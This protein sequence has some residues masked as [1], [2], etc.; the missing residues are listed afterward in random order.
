MSNLQR[1]R[2]PLILGLLLLV[3][4]AGWGGNWWLNSQKN[5]ATSGAF[6]Q[7]T[8]PTSVKLASL[9]PDIMQTTSEV[10][11]TIEA[12]NAVILKPE[13]EGRIEQILVKEGD[14][15]SKGQ[16]IIKL[17]NSDWQAQLLQAQAKLAST[18]AK[19]A[20][21][22]AGSRQ[23]DID[24]AQASLQEAKARLNNAQGGSRPEE[25]A[26]AEAQLNSA[27]AEAELAEQRVA[28][29]EGLKEEGAVSADQYQEYLTQS[30]SATAAL[31][32][33]KRRLSQLQ[34]SRRSDVTE[35]AAAV[36]REAQNLRRLQNGPRSEVIAQAKA[37]VAEA[38]AQ[39]RIAEVK[40]NKTQVIAAISGI[41]GD[42][43]VEIGDYVREGDTLTT[44]TENNLLELNLSIPLEKAPQLRLGLPVEILDLQG[45]AIASGQISFISPNV[46][47]DSQLI[48]AK[49]TFNNGNRDLLNRQFIQAKVIWEQRPGILIP[50]TAVSRLGGQTFVFVAKPHESSKEDEP[51][52]MAQ[53]RQVQLGDLQGNN[54]QVISGLEVGEKI[55]TAG[56]LQLKDGAP[57]QPLESSQK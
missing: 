57:I 12:S 43:P 11:G 41:V 40:V 38:I 32:Q 7:K 54:Y 31:E 5:A 15:V 47:A 3:V 50:A 49:A 13:I 18:Q 24:E 22:Q 33:A 56:I 2:W 26:Q 20:E 42:I 6:A 37:D 9:K 10:V 44:L 51:K 46:T 34:K 4:G 52:L 53:Q 45:K 19:L 28:R 25:V 1:R 35:L 23:E 27:Q 17:D 21:L 36:E 48:L 30:R 16:V 14:R 39:V 29:Y 8:P 55:V